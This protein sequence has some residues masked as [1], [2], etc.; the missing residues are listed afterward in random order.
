MTRYQQ[1]T[2]RMIELQLQLAELKR[3]A[4]PNREA[5]ERIKQLTRELV[6]LERKQEA[7]S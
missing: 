4:R 5:A 7:Q 2:R 3:Q 6:A 1:L